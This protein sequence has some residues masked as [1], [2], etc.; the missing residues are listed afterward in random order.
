MQAPVRVEIAPELLSQLI[1]AA[2]QGPFEPQPW[3]HFLDLLCEAVDAK[4]GSL[5]RRWPTPQDRG[6]I[7]SNGDA[8]M[9]ADYRSKLFQLDPSCHKPRPYARTMMDQMTEAELRASRY[10]KEC[11]APIGIFHILVADTIDDSGMQSR[12]SLQRADGKPD[13]GLY[14]K[15][16][17]NLV[18]PHVQQSIAR[19]R[20]TLQLRAERQ[21]MVDTMDQ[22]C[23]GLVLLDEDGGILECNGLARHLIER[24]ADISVSNDRLRLRQSE[25]QGLLDG[26]LARTRQLIAQPPVIEALSCRG[27]GNTPLGALIKSID[28]SRLLRESNYIPHTPAV[29]V[30]LNDPSLA[31]AP[32]D[33][34]LQILFGL[35]RA[36]S[37]LAVLLAEGL[38]TEEAATRLGVSTNTVRTQI[39]SIFAK[40]GVHRQSRLAALFNRSLAALH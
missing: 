21:L 29:A 36:E 18:L 8:G 31:K 12:L 13:F 14:E 26:V 4:V 5:V 28:R 7:Y 17:L 23:V 3:Q 30:L 10:H 6:L 16:L 32:S 9:I 40:T 19:H 2:W 34:V 35:S 24:S 25:H 37:S 22:L 27:E 15:T 38:S 1:Q 11:Q 33:A 39:R 20:D